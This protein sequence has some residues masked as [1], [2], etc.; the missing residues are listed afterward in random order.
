MSRVF[1]ILG[2]LSAFV[3]VALGAFAAHVLRQKLPAELY[4]VFEVGVRYHVYHALALLAVGILL[5]HFPTARLSISGW[6]FVVGTFVFSGSLY[7]YS[8]S[9][10]RWLVIVTPIGGV[11]FLAGWAWLAWVI[12]RVD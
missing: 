2:S 1:L 9:G 7:A 4:N 10:A 6:M 8:L 3:A 11:C 12:W 5:I